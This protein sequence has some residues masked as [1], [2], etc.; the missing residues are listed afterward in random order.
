MS[1]T[2]AQCIT[3]EKQGEIVKSIKH[4]RKLPDGVYIRGSVQGYPVLLTADTGASK[5]VISKRLYEAMRPEDKPKL[6]K[7][8]KLIRAGG[9]AIRELGKGEFKIQLGPV[10]L[11]VEAVV[12]E[13]DDDGLIG[14]DVLQSRRNGPSYL[15]LSKG[16]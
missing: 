4:V 14:V 10:D 5:T 15:L 2:N 1:S 9:T 6:E 16:C 8:S 12:A 7:S 3:L 13:I 11:R